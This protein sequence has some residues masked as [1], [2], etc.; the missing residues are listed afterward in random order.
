MRKVIV[1]EFVS[2]DGV[3]EDP[4]GGEGFERGGWQIPFFDDDAGRYVSEL[5]FSCDALLLGRTTYEHFA[6]AWPAMGGDGGFG[7]RMNS[8]P[9][10]VASRTLQGRLDWNASVLEGDL[11]SVVNAHKQ[12]EGQD[13]L[14]NG[15]GKLVDSLRH[16]GL[17]DEYRIWI[18]PI[19]LGNGQ[20][21]FNDV[22]ERE[23]LELVDS[24][25]TSKGVVI[26]TY[27]PS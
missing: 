1:S 19:A 6:A 4:G 20:R 11:A 24:T 15:S 9:K 22:G 27:R 25:T 10:Y 7:D 5:L 16:E 8:L 23:T 3:M 13:I 14:V 17:V 21:L 26:C 18:H 12:E 2:L